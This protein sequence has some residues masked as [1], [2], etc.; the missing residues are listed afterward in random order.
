MI[1]VLQMN[2]SATSAYLYD[3][4]V[5]W[6][7]ANTRSEKHIC[8]VTG[9]EVCVQNSFFSFLAL[10]TF[11]CSGHITDSVPE[12]SALDVILD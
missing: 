9:R 10:P 6:L 12:P 1:C 8:H 5:T 7:F 3:E 2:S 4:V 11:M